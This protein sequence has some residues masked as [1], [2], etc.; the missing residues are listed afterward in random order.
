MTGLRRNTGKLTLAACVAVVTWAWLARPP[1]SWTLG[2]LVAV[3]TVASAVVSLR[4]T[5]RRLAAT[6]PV[7]LVV[8]FV[9]FALQASLPGDPAVVILGIGATPEAVAELRAELGLDLPLF[10][11]YLAWLGDAVVGDLGHSVLLREDVADGMSRTITPTLQLLSYSVVLALAIAVP[12]GMYAAYRANSAVDRAASYAMLGALAM[13]N[14]VVAVLLVLL[15]AVGGITVF[16][17]TVG[18]HWL[19]AAR[20]VPIGESWWL[21]AKHMAL[22][23][24]SLAVGLAAIVMRLL[25]AEAIGTLRLPFIDLA[26]SKGLSVNRVLWGHAFRPSTFTPLTVLGLAMGALIGGSL[27]IEFLFA[28]PG[29]GSYIFAGASTRDFLAV[30]GGALVVSTLFIVIL[31]MLDFAYVAIDPRLRSSEVAGRT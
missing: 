3:G 23:S 12:L 6:V 9:V 13:P 2:A 25:R 22:P 8:S 27:V 29:V 14:F 4:L 17:V 7:L 21:H 30:Q 1:V 28:I 18:G 10:E 15:L 24:L 20:Y 31:T 16:G 26:R 11:R 5:L 19:P